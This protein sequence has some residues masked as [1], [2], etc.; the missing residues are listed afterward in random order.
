M[1]LQRVFWLGFPPGRFIDLSVTSSAKLFKGD[2]TFVAENNIVERVF[3]VN[4]SLGELQPLCFVCF[5]NHLAIS[6]VLESP[7]LLFAVSSD[8]RGMDHDTTLRKPFLDL[9][10]GCFII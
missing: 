1:K 9:A 3:S 8:C 5:V 6:G 4:H 7:A 2:R 10:A